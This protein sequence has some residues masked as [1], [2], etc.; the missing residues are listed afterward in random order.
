MLLT[1]GPKMFACLHVGRPGAGHHN[2]VMHDVMAAPVFGTREL[3]PRRND[4]AKTQA[5]LG[6]L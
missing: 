3:E 4:T 5:V 1:I 2:D 6:S